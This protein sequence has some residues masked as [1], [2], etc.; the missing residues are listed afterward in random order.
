MN[1][2][3]FPGIKISAL[4]ASVPDNLKRN[5][6]YAEALS[7]GEMQKFCENTGVWQRYVS[8]DGVTASDLCVA[9]ANEVFRT[10]DMDRST[11]DGLIFLTQTPDYIHFSPP[12]A[13]V[14]Q[15]RLGLEN[16]GVA[17]DSSIGCTGFLFGMQMACAQILAGCKR[18]LVLVGDADLLRSGNNDFIKDE[19]LFGDCG[20]AVVLEKAEN[21]PPI[22]MVLHTIGKGYKAIITPYGGFRHPLSELY[23]ERG[24]EVWPEYFLKGS[25]MEG[26][27]V[28]TFSITDAPKTAKKFFQYFGCGMEDY[29]LV[30]IHQANKMIVN[31]VVKRIK[32]PKEK[33]INSLERYG[34]TRGA[35]TAIN[36]CDYAMREDV[37][38]GTKRILNLTFGIGLNVA[39]ADFELDM[40]RCLPIIKT[41]EAFDDEIDNYTYF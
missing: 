14:M 31:N 36:I 10:F 3:E 24:N 30:S 33:V 1:F 8:T 9:A 32:A 4:A 23:K 34:N 18:V 5:M 6:D 19:F 21:A 37:H 20:L 28:F 38:T 27:D 12:T 26:T 35:S 40:A 22:R 13:A 7:E 17:Y 39:V 15:Y 29:D 16:C 25:T 2:F 41:T 11:I